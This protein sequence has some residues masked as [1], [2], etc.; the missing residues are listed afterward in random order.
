MGRSFRSLRK[1]SAHHL[2]SGRLGHAGHRKRLA[3][4]SCLLDGFEGQKQSSC[5]RPYAV[6]T[7]H[8][9]AD[10][11]G[12]RSCKGKGEGRIKESCEGRRKRKGQE[13]GSATAEVAKSTKERKSRAQK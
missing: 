1:S 9:R 11:G 3:T 4:R 13:K 7:H 8:Q 6:Q 5:P 2:S 12:T 10:Q